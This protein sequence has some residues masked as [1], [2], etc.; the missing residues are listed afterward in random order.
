MQERKAR[1]RWQRVHVTLIWQMGST[2]NPF[3]VKVNQ[4]NCRVNNGQSARGDRW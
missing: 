4:V 3:P 2:A 1:A